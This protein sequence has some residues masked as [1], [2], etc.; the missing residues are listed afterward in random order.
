[1]KYIHFLLFISIAWIT[2]KVESKEP[3]FLTKKEQQLCH[4]CIAEG[5]HM[6]RL[7]GYARIEAGPN[8]FSDRFDA[9]SGKPISFR[10]TGY[11]QNYGKQMY[12][13]QEGKVPEADSKVYRG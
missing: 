12:L 11:G 4:Q 6:C 3:I 1:M 10:N 9:D 8:T 2:V 5:Q 7:G 13:E